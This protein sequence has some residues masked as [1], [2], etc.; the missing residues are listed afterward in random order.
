MKQRPMTKKRRA[1]IITYTRIVTLNAMT[2]EAVTDA[3]LYAASVQTDGLYQW[4]GKRGYIWRANR[5][6]WEPKKR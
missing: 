1:A 6:V 5:N 3:V 2:F 4:L